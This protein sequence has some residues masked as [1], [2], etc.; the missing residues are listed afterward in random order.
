MDLNSFENTQKRKSVRNRPDKLKI[1]SEKWSTNKTLH[2]IKINPI[3][4]YKN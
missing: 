4:N 3:M 2:P 1:D